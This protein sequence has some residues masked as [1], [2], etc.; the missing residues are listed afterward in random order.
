M[1]HR[2]WRTIVILG[3]PDEF[4]ALVRHAASGETTRVRYRES[5][6]PAARRCDTCGRGGCPHTQAAERAAR[7]TLTTTAKGTRT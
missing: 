4:I 3:W 1:S 6:G 5:T 2:L 7:N